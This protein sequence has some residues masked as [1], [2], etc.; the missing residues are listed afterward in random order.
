MLMT[1]MRGNVSCDVMNYTRAVHL[2]QLTIPY[3]LH[4]KLLGARSTPARIHQKT[5]DP[6]VLDDAV[7]PAQYIFRH[8]T[9][10]YRKAKIIKKNREKKKKRR[11][12]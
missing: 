12:R 5:L 2:L 7:K 6:D 1:S 11:R 9:N 8:L 10:R 4:S 3:V